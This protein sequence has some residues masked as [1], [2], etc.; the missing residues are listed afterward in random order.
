MIYRTAPFSTTSNDFWPR[1]QGYA[2][3]W[4]WIS[5]KRY[6]IQ[7]LF[8]WNTNRNLHISY[9]RVSFRM[10]LSDLQWLSEIFND[11][12]H[13]AVSLRRASCQNSV[14]KLV[15]DERTNGQTDG[16][17]CREHC[18]SGQSIDWRRH[19]QEVKVI[20]QKAPHGGPI[21]RL[22]VTPGGRNL[23]HWIPGVGFPISVP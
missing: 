6:Q 18:A 1:C 21:P 5:Q 19:K 11:T 22:G 16:R 10:I 7:T 15:A 12:K 4:C 2:I 17:T 20:W 9:S 3:I 23:Y 8:T 14:H 13:R